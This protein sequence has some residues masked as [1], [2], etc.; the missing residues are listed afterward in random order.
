MEILWRVGVRIRPASREE[1]ERLIS[2]S[3]QEQG[4]SLCYDPAGSYYACEEKKEVAGIVCLKKLTFYLGEIKHLYVS[5]KY[6]RR[7][8]AIALVKRVIEDTQLPV[9]MA[10]VLVNNKASLEIFRKAG[11]KEMGPFKSPITGR[12][13]YL[14]LKV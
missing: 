3:A 6:R 8:I 9:Y 1:A 13:L 14:M 2:L 7:G 11:F 10:T 12:E 4:C 5:P